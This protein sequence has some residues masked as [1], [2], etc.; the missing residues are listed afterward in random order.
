MLGVM[1]KN[2]DPLFDPYDLEAAADEA[3]G[4][5]PSD[6]RTA[7]E[8]RRDEEA[9]RV[10]EVGVKLA[11]RPLR[12]KDVGRT[13][14][15][16]QR[17]RI[18]LR[19]L[20]ETGIV[21]RAAARAGWSARDAYAAKAEDKEFA[22]LWANALE[23]STDALEMEARR[24]ALHGVTKPVFQQGKL[25]GHVQ[26]YSDNLMNTLLKAKRPNEF[27][28]NVKM[29]HDVKGGVLVVPGVSSESDWE[30]AASANQAEHRGNQGEGEGDPLA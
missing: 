25:V 11:A 3:L 10:D 2:R 21:S 26:E 6:P 5:V 29:E 7:E 28:E 14:N 4:L 20:A 23:F 1:S 13:L 15:K 19:G 22:D 16:T 27:R 18:F 12:P 9:E 24:R 30:K 8:R 17:M